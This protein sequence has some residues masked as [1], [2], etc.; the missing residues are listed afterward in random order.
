METLHTTSF[1][2]PG[3]AV[4]KAR[5]R[6]MCRRKGKK[7]YAMMYTPQTT[8]DYEGLVVSSS[9]FPEGWPLDADYIVQLDVYHPNNVYGDLD[10]IAKSVLDGLN[11]GAEAWNDDKQVSGLYLRRGFDAENPRVEV[12]ISALPAQKYE[13]PKTSSKRRATP[14]A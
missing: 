6:A 10:N 13:K 12:T 14:E 8:Q 7:L 3:K 5:P 11:N 2:V 4:P 1:I 9:V